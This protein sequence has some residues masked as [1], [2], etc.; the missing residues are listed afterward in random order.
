MPNSTSR[1]QRYFMVV[2]ESFS[3]K[4]KIHTKKKFSPSKHVHFFI[5]SASVPE[6]VCVAHWKQHPSQKHSHLSPFTINSIII[7][8]HNYTSTKWLYSATSALCFNQDPSRT[9]I[10]SGQNINSNI[11]MIWT[12]CGR[13]CL[14]QIVYLKI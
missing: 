4:Y 3:P 11:C 5:F 8:Y 2:N 9:V 1:L 7:L 14:V 13:I 12:H 10:V 6:H